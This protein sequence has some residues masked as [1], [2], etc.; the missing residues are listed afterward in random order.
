MTT[1]QSNRLFGVIMFL[2]TLALAGAAGYLSVTGFAMTF[3]ETFWQALALAAA[4]EVGK[5]VSASFLYRYWRDISKS[6]RNG[7][8]VAVTGLM[9]FTSLGIYGYL[10]SS[11]QSSSVTLN[12]NTTIL[13]TL[14]EER[15]KLQE[16]KMEIDKQIS[17]LPIDYVSARQ[18]LQASFGP[19]QERATSR[20]AE[21]DSEVLKLKQETIKE[22]A[23]VGPVIFI[24]KSLGIPAESAI[25][26]FIF[27]VVV[28]FD[29]LAVMMTLAT[30][31]VMMKRK[32]SV[33]GQVDAATPI[34]PELTESVGVDKDVVEPQL[35]TPLEADRTDQLMTALEELRATQQQITDALQQQRRR[36]MIW[37]S[38]G[39]PQ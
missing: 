33:D 35:T 32:D 21:I 34:T 26:W 14:E 8:I 24:A 13:A 31:H 3:K 9:L 4:L 36:E 10:S 16:R 27:L 6:L 19:E 38:V 23:H 15:T 30:N 29:P 5:L 39:S 22:E 2:S 20:I 11:Y 7:M 25:N 18:K 12:T 1:P 37:Q 28:V 17:N